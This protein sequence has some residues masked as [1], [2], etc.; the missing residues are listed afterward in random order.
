MSERV[1]VPVDVELDER[2]NLL[3]HQS[4]N[5]RQYNT[6]EDESKFVR[7]LR[8]KSNAVVT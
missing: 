5:N 6:G 7:R 1:P 3:N 4:V 2:L 8:G